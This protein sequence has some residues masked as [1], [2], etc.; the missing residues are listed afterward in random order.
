MKEI[1]SLSNG[2]WKIMKLLWSNETMTVGQIVTAVEGDTDWSKNTVFTMLKRLEEKGAVRMLSTKRPQQ[3]IAT[4]SKKQA[5]LEET[6]SF[7]TRVYDGSLG[8]F[9]SALS[10]YRGLSQKEI[11]ELRAILDKAEEENRKRRDGQ[12]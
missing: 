7:L 1:I 2:E 12:C 8:L 5:A 3:Y 4:I 10:G 6:G 11:D 9:V